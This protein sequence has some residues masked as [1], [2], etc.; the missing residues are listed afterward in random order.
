[1][2]GAVVDNLK[3]AVIIPLAKYENSLFRAKEEEPNVQKNCFETLEIKSQMENCKQSLRSDSISHCRLVEKSQPKLK[4]AICVQ[5]SKDDQS[6]NIASESHYPITPS[7]VYKS[8]SF[9]TP[10]KTNSTVRCWLRGMEVY[11]SVLKSKQM[12]QHLLSGRSA[13]HIR[14]YI[15]LSYVVDRRCSIILIINTN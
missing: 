15:S 6:I 2:K 5:N 10:S 11:N 4:S 8:D 14:D 9:C 7:V 1:M 13:L 3:S 12:I